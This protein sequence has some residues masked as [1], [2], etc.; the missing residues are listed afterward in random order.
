MAFKVQREVNPDTDKWY[1]VIDMALSK[2]GGK[3]VTRIFFT[4]EEATYFIQ[5]TCAERPKD[6]DSYRIEEI[7]DGDL[8]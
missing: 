7:E 2:P 1:D 4:E 5:S 6:I 8:L 3:K